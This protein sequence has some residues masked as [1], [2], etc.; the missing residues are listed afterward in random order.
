MTPWHETQAAR[1]LIAD[2]V[3]DPPAKVVLRYRFGEQAA[4]Y[5]R[6]DDR[7][8]ALRKLHRTEEDRLYHRADKTSLAEDRAKRARHCFD[9]TVEQVIDAAL[10][11][12]SERRAA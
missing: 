2:C 5:D 3:A 12:A 6:R 10:A 7:V 9:L 4:K 11:A 1:S 8:A